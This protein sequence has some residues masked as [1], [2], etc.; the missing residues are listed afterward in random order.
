MIIILLSYICERKY[1]GLRRYKEVNSIAYRNDKE[2]ESEKNKLYMG[3]SFRQR[4]KRANNLSF[5][6]SKC[7]KSCPFSPRKV[8][9]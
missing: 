4:H 7:S 5:K 6:G 2:K 3:A 9:A 8:P 1:V